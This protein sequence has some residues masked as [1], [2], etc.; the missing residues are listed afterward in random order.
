MPSCLS[1]S[2]H[3]IEHGAQQI[4]KSVP[5]KKSDLSEMIVIVTVIQT[6]IYI[7]IPLTFPFYR[8]SRLF[9]SE[10][11]CSFPYFCPYEIITREIREIF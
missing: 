9:I 8:L 6:E 1:V 11:I 10:M 4:C 7:I 2:M 3:A 5:D